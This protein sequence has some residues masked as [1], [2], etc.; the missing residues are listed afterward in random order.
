[1]VKSKSRR[2]DGCAGK[3]RVLTWGVLAS[4]LKGQRRKTEREVSRGRSSQ[5]SD[6]GPNEK[7]SQKI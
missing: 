7:E 3:D 5:D 6:E 1:M 4:C 2:S